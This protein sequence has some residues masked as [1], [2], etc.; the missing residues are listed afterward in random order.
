VILLGRKLLS[1]GIFF[2]LM[3]FLLNPT[4]TFIQIRVID[5]EYADSI[6]YDGELAPSTP[7][8]RE[9]Y[10]KLLVP[11]IS[12]EQGLKT[13]HELIKQPNVVGLSQ[14]N[15]ILSQSQF[16]VKEFKRIF[17]AFA[18]NIYYT[19]PDRANLYLAGGATPKPA[20]S[21]AY[22]L[23]ND[24]LTNL[25]ALQAEVVYLLRVLKTGGELE[26]AD[27]LEYGNNCNDA[28][29]KYMALVPPEELKMAR[30]IWEQQQQK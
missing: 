22:L 8:M 12:I 9:T 24:I 6:K 23:R 15:E 29:V 14:A 25:D 13:V 28:M 26:S 5:Q 10:A 1:D 19:D 7:Q 21:L 20:Q 16:K 17:N 18:D 4:I 27:L 2:V 30:G 3:M 11:I